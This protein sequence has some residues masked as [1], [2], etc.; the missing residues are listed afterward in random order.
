MNQDK[1]FSLKSLLSENCITAKGKETRQRVA[2]GI[3]QKWPRMVFKMAVIEG[4]PWCLIFFSLIH[5]LWGNQLPFYTWALVHVSK[6]L[7]SDYRCHMILYVVI[8]WCSHI[9]PVHHQIPFALALST[10]SLR[11]PIKVGRNHATR[12]NRSGPTAILLCVLLQNGK[13]CGHVWLEHSTQ[14]QKWSS[15]NSL[16]H[17]CSFSIALRKW[18]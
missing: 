9:S 7:P 14:E 2:N 8:L 10:Y 3:L 1:P 17:P 11:L 16:C 12:L 18:F 4:M 6:N 15:K 5:S 13:H